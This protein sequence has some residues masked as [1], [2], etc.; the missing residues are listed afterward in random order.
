[1]SNL[2]VIFCHGRAWYSKIIEQ[3]ENGPYS[4][5][6]GLILNSTLES[7]GVKEYSDPYP[8]VWLHPPDKYKDGQD[9]TFVIVDVPNL[10]AAE[11]EARKLIGSVYGYVD[12]VNGGIEE[13]FGKQLPCDGTLTMN[14]SETWA[15]IL[16]TGEL[17][18][19]PDLEPDSITPQ[20][21]Y[22]ALI[23]HG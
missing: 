19:L 12:C 21:L 8:G 11:D 22:E 14:C 15:R 1:M 23:N 9:A 20:M 4:H 3:V 13:L 16:R 7:E 18:V 5:V 10:A 17:N 2:T 6:A